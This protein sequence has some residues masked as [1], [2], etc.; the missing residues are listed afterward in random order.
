MNDLKIEWIGQ[1]YR[2][3]LVGNYY[4]KNCG[5]SFKPTG[6]KPTLMRE[7][8]RDIPTAIAIG[9]YL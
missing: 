3:K 6:M 1:S 5:P 7:K 4:K 8:P 9:Y 2:P